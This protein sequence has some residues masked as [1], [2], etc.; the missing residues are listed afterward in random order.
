M[1]TVLHLFL[2]LHLL[3]FGALFGG[4]L[5]QVREPVK[6]VNA[7]MRDGIGT[8]VVAGIVMVGI[9]EP[10]YHPGG[11][12]HAWMTVKLLVGLVILGLVMAN[13]RKPR[14]SQGLWGLILALTV[15]NVGVATLW[16][17]N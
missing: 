3:G 17:T 14:I 7:A 13:L 8:A 10:K 6:R 15:V 16:Q 11:E 2:L 5:V 4:L 12:F 1:T 9:I